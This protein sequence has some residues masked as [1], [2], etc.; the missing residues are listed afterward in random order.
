MSTTTTLSSSEN[1]NLSNPNQAR[2]KI[3]IS[4]A[5]VLVYFA[6]LLLIF[7]FM[8]SINDDR[9]IMEIVCGKFSNATPYA[10]FISTLFSYPLYFLYKLFPNFPVYG[11]AYVVEMFLV[12]WFIT[13]FVLSKVQQNIK[14]KAL[15]ITITYLT[16][17]P[18]LVLTQFTFVTAILC[19]PLVIISVYF[20]KFSKKEKIVYSVLFALFAFLSVGIRYQV[21]LMSVPFVGLGVV[22]GLSKDKKSFI[23]TLLIVL[24]TVVFLFNLGLNKIILSNDENYKNF[25]EY[26][27]VRSDLYDYYGFPDYDSNREFYESLS[28]DKSAYELLTHYVFDIPEASLENMRV[29]R[30]YQLENSTKSNRFIIK[31]VYEGFN[32]SKVLSSL[33][34]ILIV[35][36]CFCGIKNKD[37]RILFSILLLVI[38]TLI[39]SAFIAYKMKFPVRIAECLLLF[40]FYFLIAQLTSFENSP[41]KTKTSKILFC[42]MGILMFSMFVHSIVKTYNYSR[43]IKSYCNF[44]QGLENELINRPENIYFVEKDITIPLNAYLL[45]STK[46]VTNQYVSDWNVFSTFYNSLMKELKYS[47]FYDLLNN[48]DNFY[49]VTNDLNVINRYNEY[50]GSRFNKKFVNTEEILNCKIWFL[51]PV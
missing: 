1:K 17:L 35:T 46:V 15:F 36:N 16:L 18:F 19:F 10:I 14:I 3:W 47:S 24:M 48:A 28:I 23:S 33:I 49:L 8:F 44:Y 20:N 38:G 26:N 34:I 29:I 7:N 2:K 45:K 39:M 32:G 5:I 11:F 4:F 6:L 37:K 51:C 22:L 9:Q 21:F 42:I 13:F 50:V 43:G 27:I 40:N 12:L 30:D 31:T 41:I 25:N